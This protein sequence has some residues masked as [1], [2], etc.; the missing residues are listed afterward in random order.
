MPRKLTQEEFE[1]KVRQ[2]DPSFK[3]IGKYEGYYD[4]A[5]RGR[6]ILLEHDCGYQ[7]E[8]SIPKLMA[9][10]CKCRKCN[11]LVP[12][13]KKEFELKI[14]NINPNVQIVGEFRGVTKNITCRC[15]VCNNEWTT[16]AYM[17][18]EH[19]CPFCAGVRKTH[20]MFVSEINDKFQNRY[21]ILS[22]YKGIH[23]RILVKSKECGHEFE[24]NPRDLL[25]GDCKC[26]YCNGKRIL[27]GFNDLW[28]TN[29]DIARFLENKNDGYSVTNR[30]AKKFWWKC[31]CGNR[32]YKSVDEVV[33]ANSIRCPICSDGFPI[34]EKVIYSLLRYLNIEFDFR[35]KFNWSLNKQY[36][37]YIPNHSLIIEVN[38]LQHYK[39]SANFTHDTLENIQKNDKLKYNL[40]IQNGIINY[41]YVDTSTSNSDDIIS[42]IKTSSLCTILNLSALSPYDWNEILKRSLNSMVINV[43]K[44]W[45]DG[46]SIS[47][48]QNK[49]KIDR[50]TIRNYL[51]RT[52][53][54]GLCDYSKEES[55]N[56]IWRN[57]AK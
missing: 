47:E 14:Y 57:Y 39:E 45:N 37:F 31:D 8:Y 5:G 49:V 16:R 50:H 26:P 7:D 33:S 3:V 11:N 25:N 2:I 43:S 9:K 30:S 22:E 38:G 17:L 42:N 46:L 44:L 6:K 20:K 13:T 29:P 52:T 32:V 10:K 19:G 12:R 15:S 4:E 23:N 56:R 18:Y 28:T 41:V 34:G 1:Q 40:S 36:D 27:V 21:E 54:I 55:R 48:I 53:K 35:I 51:K 24:C